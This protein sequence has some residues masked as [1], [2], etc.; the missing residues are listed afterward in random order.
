[1][2]N[3]LSEWWL[4]GEMFTIELKCKHMLLQSFSNPPIV[5]ASH[6]Q[7]QKKLHNDMK[8]ISSLVK[9]RGGEYNFLD[10]E[11]VVCS[12]NIWQARKPRSYD[13]LTSGR[14]TSVEC[15]AARVDKN[16]YIKKLTIEIR[17][18]RRTQYISIKKR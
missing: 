2:T 7:V 5:N 15:R 9:T 13:N 17:L 10:P 11:T 14:L 1:M 3:F 8:A 12:I 4:L 18:F 6:A 16:M